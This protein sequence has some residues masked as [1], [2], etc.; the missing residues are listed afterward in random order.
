M[1]NSYCCLAI[2][3][4]NHYIIHNELMVKIAENINEKEIKD[5]NL[6]LKNECYVKKTTSTL[7]PKTEEDNDFINPLPKIVIIKRKKNKN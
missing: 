5:N 2:E 4:S 1:G 6:N 3:K 7:S